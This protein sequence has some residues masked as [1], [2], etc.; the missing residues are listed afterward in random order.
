MN[1]KVNSRPFD[2]LI[3]WVSASITVAFV[4]WSLVFPET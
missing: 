3:F 4:V 2:P 1:E